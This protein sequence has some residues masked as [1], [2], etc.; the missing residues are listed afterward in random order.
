MVFKNK[1]IFTLVSSYQYT[2]AP[3][4]L[5]IT[6][7]GFNDLLSA[8]CV[9]TYLLSY[10]RCRFPGTGTVH[11]LTFKYCNYASRPCSKS[12]CCGAGKTK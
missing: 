10:S 3:T 7:S 11:L 9:F 12:T 1:N 5:L 6:V 4:E 2:S 8:A